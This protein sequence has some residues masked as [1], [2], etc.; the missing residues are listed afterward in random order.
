MLIAVTRVLRFAFVTVLIFAGTL[1]ARAADWPDWRGPNRDGRSPEKDLPSRWSPAGENLLWKAPYPGRSTP[2]ILGGRLYAFNGAGEGPGVQERIVCLDAASGQLIWE[3][4]YNVFHSD[5]P[6]HRIAWSSPVADPA[7]GNVYAYGVA[8]T[9]TALSRDGKLLWRRELLEEFGVASTHGGRTVSPVI[10]GDLV[11]TSALT[12]GWGEQARGAHRFLAFDKNTGETVWVATTPY[13]PYDTTYS[14]PIGADLNGMRLIIAGAGDGAVHALKA[15]TGEWVW[16]FPMSKRGI[17]TGV[18]LYG[19]TVFVSHGEENLDTS[20]MG[21]IAAIDG[22]AKGEIALGQVKWAVKGFLGGYS[23]PVI[24]GDQ[25]YQIDNGSNLFAFDAVSGRRLWQQNLGTI[26]KA[27]PVLADGK[28]YV[29]NENGKFFILKP[30]RDR[31]EILSAVQLGTEEHPEHIVASA[32]VSGGRVY[33]VSDGAMYCFGRQAPPASWAR[34]PAPPAESGSGPAAHVQVLPTEIIVAPGQAVQ[35]RARL[36]DEKGRFLREAKAAWTLE[37]L[38]GQIGADGRY[39][40][41]PGFYAGRVKAAVDGI[42]GAARVR[43]V[44]PLPWE[45]QFAA[46]KPGPP[47]PQWVGSTGKFTVREIDGTNRLVKL[48]DNPF[49]KRARVFMGPTDWRDYTVQVD[50]QATERR[51]QM[52]D[53]GVIA[54]RYA[55]ILFG[56]DQ[57][58]EIQS[59]QAH[60]A[61]TLRQPFPWKKDT[62]Y[63]MKLRVENL[64]DGKV[65][66]SGKVWPAGEPEPEAWTIEQLDAVGNREGSPGIYADAPFEI[67]FDNLKVT[68]N[69]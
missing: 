40:P 39:S 22:A 31:C 4:R 44:A 68:P 36:F 6:P 20:E 57:R 35:F 52:G 46:L 60:T 64:P 62:W 27:S 23:S 18:V 15:Q 63:R 50:V 48:A 42:E 37:G 1:P 65:R 17:N 55:L 38:P 7:T 43:V 30:G 59:W 8:G 61:R 47:P 10:E 32:A 9:L 21:L 24:D 33:V 49:T 54:Q 41:P 2:V 69:Q 58:V 45:L 12:S 51:R 28:L 5:V 34:R 25:I 67:L 14:T 66:A 56:N 19:D 11:I 26:Q 3:H 53:A 16:H 29:G 13:R